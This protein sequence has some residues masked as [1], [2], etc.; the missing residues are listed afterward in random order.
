MS[1]AEAREISQ[2][3]GI[4]LIDNLGLYLGTR[5]IHGKVTSGMYQHIL[6]KIMKLKLE[7]WKAKYLTMAGRITLGQY[8]LA[9]T[10]IYHMHAMNF[11]PAS[12][13][14]R[15]EW[16]KTQNRPKHL[17]MNMDSGLKSSMW[18]SMPLSGRLPPLR[19]WPT[20]EFPIDSLQL[21]N[22]S[23]HKPHTKPPLR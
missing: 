10:L 21:E 9:S 19:R 12:P 15:L 13:L 14:K 5:S 22:L 8:V 23:F 20:S 17:Y 11:G 3:L 7:S 1:N 16:I 4:P 6:D 18:T 2:I